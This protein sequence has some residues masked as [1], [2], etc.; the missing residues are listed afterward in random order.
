M[1]D[2]P[3]HTRQQ[4]LE[5]AMAS[6]AGAATDGTQ[7]GWNYYPPAATGNPP[8]LPGQYPPHPPQQFQPI[9][10]INNFGPMMHPNQNFGFMQH[11]LQQQLGVPPS[12]G[13]TSFGQP[14]FGIGG[15]VGFGMG[16]AVPMMGTGQQQWYGTHPANAYNPQQQQQQQGDGM[17][18]NVTFGGVTAARGP[19][20]MPPTPPTIAT[21]QP[22]TAT[23][24]AT[25]T[26]VTATATGAGAGGTAGAAAPATVQQ[27]A[28][29]APAPVQQGATAAPT[30]GG[31]QVTQPGGG[32]PGGDNPYGIVAK[33]KS[34]SET[35]SCAQ[36]KHD[37]NWQAEVLGETAK[38]QQLKQDVF[39]AQE[40]FRQ[41]GFMRKNSPFVQKVH[42]IASFNEV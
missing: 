32:T 8:Q 35:F 26:T 27:V 10:P 22:A 17:G 24:S 28:A 31:Q 37:L 34:Q 36:Y 7:G 42:S 1:A 19:E 5:Q 3:N 16:T 4:A 25:A 9:T 39:L 14:N 33:M 29:A 2:N 12:P 20:Q 13:G 23:A 21:V 11:Q 18:N 15:N 38:E 40:S 6:A 41:F 30:N